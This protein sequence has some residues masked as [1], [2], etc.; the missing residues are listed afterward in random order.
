M[1]RCSTI[2]YRFFILMKFAK[3]SFQR[4]R[5]WFGV[6]V[7]S[8]EISFQTN[9]MYDFFRAKNKSIQYENCPN[10]SPF[11]KKTKNKVNI[12]KVWYLLQNFEDFVTFGI[13][14]HIRKILTRINAEI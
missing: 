3:T 13:F 8:N 7:T 1:P 6:L 2:T 9:Y 14:Y 12:I 10:L 5:L 11:F 4:I